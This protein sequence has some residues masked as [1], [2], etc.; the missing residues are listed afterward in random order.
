MKYLSETYT[1]QENQTIDEQVSKAGEPAVKVEYL[2]IMKSKTN[3]YWKKHG[4]NQSFNI[5][6][7][8]IFRLCLYVPVIDNVADIP[9]IIFN[10]N[11]HS[12]IC[13]DNQ[14]VFMMQIMIIF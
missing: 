4:T 2:G 9:R 12:R 5:S 8:T 11:N 10:K 3:W 6:N 7:R 1:P 13:I 14:F